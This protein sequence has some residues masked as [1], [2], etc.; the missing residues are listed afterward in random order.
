L[1]HSILATEDVALERKAKTGSDWMVL[2][3]DHT[4][5]R[6]VRFGRRVGDHLEP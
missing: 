6:A 3:Q 1:L 5:K 4:A 2:A